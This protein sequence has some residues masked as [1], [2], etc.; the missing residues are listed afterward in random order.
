MKGKSLRDY[1]SLLITNHFEEFEE[2]LANQFFS[3]F[4]KLLPLN[5]PHV[6]LLVCKLRRIRKQQL[7][8]LKESALNSRHMDISNSV[9]HTKFVNF[10]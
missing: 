8:I 3:D 4:G 9:D 6:D 1:Y 7:P 5:Y 2:K 10:L